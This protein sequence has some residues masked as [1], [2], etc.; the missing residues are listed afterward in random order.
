MYVMEVSE[1]TMNLRIARR[2]CLAIKL[3][4]G[5]TCRTYQE[6]TKLLQLVRA[7]SV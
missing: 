1:Q 7:L 3:H 5:Q 2:A 6:A 4:L